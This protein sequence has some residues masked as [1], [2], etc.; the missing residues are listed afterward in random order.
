MLVYAYGDFIIIEPY[1]WYQDGD[2]WVADLSIIGQLDENSKDDLD[3]FLTFCNSSEVNTEAKVLAN[4]VLRQK[5]KVSQH[6][7]LSLYKN[8]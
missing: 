4:L 7:R 6:V 2:A 1:G 5:I 8:H 3:D